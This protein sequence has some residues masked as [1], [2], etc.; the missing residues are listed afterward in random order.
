MASAP[1]LPPSP[2]DSTPSATQVR[3]VKV[4]A[5]VRPKV[6]AA[7]RLTMPPAPTMA[8]A[9]VVLAPAPV[10][11]VPA[12]R[13]TPLDAAELPRLP[14]VSSPPSTSVLLA[15]SVAAGA[16]RRRLALPNVSVPLS[17][18]RVLA[19]DVPSMRLLPVLVRAPAP[20]SATARPPSSK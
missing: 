4:L 6:V 14:S 8:P 7:P 19:D 18:A 5:P 13:S 16:E 12:F 17:M 3:P 2:T 11:S 15:A 20:R 9:K 1:L 10:V